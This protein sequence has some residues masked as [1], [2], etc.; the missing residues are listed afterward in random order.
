MRNLIKNGKRKE[1]WLLSL[2]AKSGEK[3]ALRLGR[4][5][6]QNSL[7]QESVSLIF[8]IMRFTVTVRKA[9]ALM[10]GMDSTA[11]SVCV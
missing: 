11:T 10:P 8:E 1:Y 7:F 2:T 5:R 3:C 6:A 4:N 9:P